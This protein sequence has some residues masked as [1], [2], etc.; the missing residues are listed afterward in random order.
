M[1]K[2]SN[3]NEFN[4]LFR[5]SSIFIVAIVILLASFSQALAMVYY[6]S[7]TGSETNSGTT[8]SQA[9]DKIS[10]AVAIAN[11]GDE[12][13][14]ASGQYNERLVNRV[15]DTIAVN[16]ALYGGFA[17]GESSLS[18][19]NF[20]VNKTIIN[21]MNEGILIK[22]SDS[23]ASSTR[24]DG[25]YI[26]G[27]RGFH[28]GGI[29]TVASA[30]IITNNTI[31]NNYSNGLGGGISVWGFHPTANQ[32]PLITGNT[33]V[34]NY[35][36][37]DAGDGGGIGITY[38]N[39]T[40]TKNV[41]SRNYANQNGGAIAIYNGSSP[42]IVSNYILANS[43][44]V[45]DGG[46]SCFYGGGGVFVATG[47][48]INCEP[49]SPI[50][51]H[52]KIA[53]NIIAANGAY[54]GGGVM[55]IASYEEV[56]LT[57]NTIASNSGA[58]IEWQDSLINLSNNIIAYNSEG[59]K[60]YHSP[61]AGY[62]M[63]NNN[64]YGNELQL[65]ETDYV[66]LPDQT[67][68]Q[69]NIS[70][71]PRMANYKIGN[72]H[73]Q[74]DSPCLNAGDNLSASGL[75]ADIEGTSRIL[76]AVIDIGADES[77]GTVWNEEEPVIRVSKSG[78]GSD[79]L[80]W[81]TAKQ[82]VSA[83]IQEAAK[84]GGEVWVAAGMYYEH[85]KP[86]AFVHLYG[87]F[88]GTESNLSERDWGQHQTTLDGG[89]QINVAI[90]ENSGYRVSILDGFTVQNGGVYTGGVLPSAGQEGVGGGIKITVGGPELVHNKIEHNA[91][92]FCDIWPC[93]NYSHGGGV[94]GYLST[95]TI[96]ENTI[97]D[98]EVWYAGG[99]GGGLYFLRSYPL[100]RD[101]II[102]R[103][104]SKKGSGVYAGFS[105][106]YI[107]G[108]VVEDNS[109]YVNAFTLA[110]VLSSS[111]GAVT[112]W[113]CEDF[114][115]ER[116]T[117]RGNEALFGAGI[118]VYSVK[119]GRIESNL[120][121]SNSAWNWHY[122]LNGLPAY[123]GGIYVDN[124]WSGTGIVAETDII[125]ITNNTLVNNISDPL[126]GSL[127]MDLAT[128]KIIVANNIVA[129]NSSGISLNLALQ[130]PPLLEYNNVY[131]NDGTNYLNLS[132]GLTNTQ[133][134]PLFVNYALDDFAL[135]PASPCIESGSLDLLPISYLDLV[136]NIRIQDGNLDGFPRIDKGAYEFVGPYGINVSPIYG[137]ETSESGGQ[138]S[139]EVYLMRKP[140]A[141]VGITLASSD[142]T[143]GITDID[144]V[145]FTTDNWYEKQRVNI[146]GVND[147]IID[148]DVRYKIIT[149]SI[150][151]ADTAYSGMGVPDVLVI[152]LENDLPAPVTTCPGQYVIL[153]NMVFQTGQNFVCNASLAISTE[154][155]VRVETGSVVTFVA[156]VIRLQPGFQVSS[157][158][159]FRVLH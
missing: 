78:D 87:G 12:I 104:H 84:T 54:Q 154:G 24:I 16:V 5:K 60:Y 117:I 134:D 99:Y 14:V 148:F 53:N 97:Q 27:G 93:E 69:W 151:S 10:D 142:S 111:H 48:D 155:V 33:I 128:N 58:G 80:T 101:N 1:G 105:A 79:G 20:E 122:P 72:F 121:D 6:V 114:R 65:E 90:F 61:T 132:P 118:T 108:N 137:L 62:S 83:G 144:A 76:D 107:I 68:I 2:V 39:P 32:H 133:V 159:T 136:P 21:G 123:G 9:K 17:G 13:W 145:V 66:G 135:S 102:R 35:A 11:E 156:P 152:N 158:G 64:V 15:I 106:P 41:I 138:D 153:R 110:N 22:I 73:I 95:S 3:T 96:A 116:N 89:G 82:S 113:L 29:K 43:A 141:S 28:G 34:E 18:E 59:L 37:E 100:I 112:C 119:K 71:E 94:S 86:P 36:F 30:P 50:G 103:N 31:F 44:N 74:P 149:G 75:I 63:N 109:M 26:T 40:I 85:I 88:S 150:T 7:P 8:W 57:N 56:D 23:A 81:G 46:S 52:P 124:S 19:R 38:S 120:I 42:T 45:L 125:R 98:N 4:Y 126:F 55:L 91:V 25:F 47:W 49:T 139:F 157:G 129:Y 127:L 92:G 130:G 67:G 140:E 131:G 77:D 51:S 115:I 146:F 147:K 143:E 70:R